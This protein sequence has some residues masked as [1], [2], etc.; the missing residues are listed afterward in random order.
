VGYKNVVIIGLGTLGGYVAEA[1]ANVEGI[2]KIV[3]IDHDIVEQKNLKNSIY[4]Q[5]DIGS[6]KVEALKD[7]LSQQ[8]LDLEIWAFQT[9]YVEGTTKLPK[10][11]LVIDCRDFTYDRQTEIDARFYISS[12]YLMADFRKNVTYKQQ[13]AGKYILQLSKNDLQHAASIVSMMIHSNTIES[14]IASQSV[15]KYELDYVKHMGECYYD[16]V[17]ENAV[18]E[19]KF[20]NLPEK[21]VPIMNM[22]KDKDVTLFLGSKVYPVFEKVIPMNTL[23]DS[24]DVIMN[25]VSA[26]ACQQ[27]FNNFVVSIFQEGDNFYI[28]LIPETGAA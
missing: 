17:Y 9:E 25:L 3:I 16:V 5:I 20:V 23:K 4:R 13:Q 28:E 11:D 22:N 18:G 21:I 1:V 19:E 6:P 24:K 12:R 2:E 15:Q 26:V 14:L 8:N 27:D 7:I 10:E